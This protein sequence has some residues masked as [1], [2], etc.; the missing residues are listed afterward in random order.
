MNC[1]LVC[2]GGE[3]KPPCKSYDGKRADACWV[4]A[5]SHKTQSFIKNRGQQKCLD[6]ALQCTAHKSIFN[7]YSVEVFLE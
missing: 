4:M 3:T 2:G 5:Y 7:L 1:H 6:K